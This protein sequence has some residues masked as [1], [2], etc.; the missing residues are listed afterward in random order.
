MARLEES[1]DWRPFRFRIQPFTNAFQNE[2]Y[3]RGI[4]EVDCGIKKIKQYLWT[5][6]LIARFNED[7]KK[8]KSRGNHIWL[9]DARK[10]PTGGWDF[11]EFRRRIAGVPKQAYVNCQWSWRLRIWDPQIPSASIRAVFSAPVLPP[12]CRWEN[13]DDRQVLLGT[14]TSKDDSTFLRVIAHYVFANHL[15]EL[16]HS[17]N[18]EILDI[19]SGD[20]ASTSAASDTAHAAPVDGDTLPSR[21]DDVAPSEM[22][23]KMADPQESVQEAVV[24]PS[25]V[26]N[27]LQAIAFPFT[28]P[29]QTDQSV[30]F[31]M[32]AEGS[33]P[34]PL[35]TQI[36]A[37]PQQMDPATS[38]QAVH[39]RSAIEERQ[40]DQT[41]DLLLNIP[42]A[43][44]RNA[45]AADASNQNAP[46]SAKP[47]MQTRNFN[48]MLS[49]ALPIS[50]A[51]SSNLMDAAPDARAS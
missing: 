30:S 43:P 12:W 36:P 19:P 22:D 51:P 31:Y 34:A 49:P 11:R 14:P 1:P 23:S 48:P 9:I 26:S 5:Q 37:V 28:P 46:T 35:P 45:I 39:L 47:A 33:H 21:A 50:P 15:H 16:E 25:Q 18:L 42:N 17:V 24:A 40:Q 3:S 10:L 44:R 7:G 20:G 6:K 32:G 38:L 2:V 13:E 29:I 41:R 8:A 4:S 27:V